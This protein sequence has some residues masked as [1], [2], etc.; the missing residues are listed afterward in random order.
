MARLVVVNTKNY[1]AI[2]YLLAIPILTVGGITIIS[3]FKQKSKS[4]ANLPKNDNPKKLRKTTKKSNE[5]DVLCN[6]CGKKDF[7]SYGRLLTHIE[8]E[9]KDDDSIPNSNNENDFTE[10]NEKNNKE[11]P[12]IGNI[13][14]VSE[15]DSETIASNSTVL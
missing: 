2:A 13:E 9:H 8:L 1:K 12:N 11:S 15:T 3:V 5:D 4:R 7:V 14:D 10:N 6:L